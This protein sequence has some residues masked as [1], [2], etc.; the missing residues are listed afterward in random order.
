MEV[1]ARRVRQLDRRHS[2][3]QRLRLHEDA[4]DPAHGDRR[5]AA[6]PRACNAPTR[7]TTRATPLANNPESVGYAT[8]ASTTVVSARTR[9]KRTTLF[10]AALA[11]NASFNW[12]TAVSPQ[13]AVIFNSVVGCGTGAPTGGGRSGAPPAN[14]RPPGTPPRSPAGSGTARTSSADRSPSRSTAAPAEARRTPGRA[15]RTG[16]VQ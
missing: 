16:D 14:R 11:S 3:W 8:F 13:R 2:R 6:K 4:A 7:T 5:V 1:F 15:R 12:F 10:S 9:S